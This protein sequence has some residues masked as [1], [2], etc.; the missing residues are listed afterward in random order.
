MLI[1][2][3][4]RPDLFVR[5]REKA[6]IRAFLCPYCHHFDFEFIPLLLYYPKADRLVFV[7]NCNWPD[8]DNQH[9]ATT[10]TFSLCTNLKPNADGAE[11]QKMVTEYLKSTIILDEMHLMSGQVPDPDLPAIWWTPD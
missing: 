10:L 1:D 3:A 6:Q 9:L 11:L 5:C 4:E 7:P 8:E 2:V